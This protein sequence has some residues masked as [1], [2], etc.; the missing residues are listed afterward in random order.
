MN[1]ESNITTT[2][3]EFDGWNIPDEAIDWEKVEETLWAVFHC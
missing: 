3:D 1:T 2:N